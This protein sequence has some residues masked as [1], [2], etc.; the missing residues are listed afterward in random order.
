[1]I[2]PEIV[3]NPE[4]SSLG[5][6]ILFKQP[7][8]IPGI[9]LCKA[10]NDGNDFQSLTHIHPLNFT[11]LFC[12]PLLPFIHYFQQ[13]HDPGYFIAGQSGKG[14]KSFKSPTGRSIHVLYPIND[15]QKLRR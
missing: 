1:M 5:I 15:C 7:P 2:E 14:K 9:S 12:C 11:T 6:D 10:G 13:M 8:G 4:K 3:I